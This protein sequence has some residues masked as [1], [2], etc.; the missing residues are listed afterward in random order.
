M[1]SNVVSQKNGIVKVTCNFQ[2]ITGHI[3]ADNCSTALIS[4]P[5]AKVTCIATN[6]DGLISGLYYLIQM[7]GSIFFSGITIG[8]CPSRTR[9]PKRFKALVTRFGYC[10]ARTFRQK[11]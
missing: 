8:I 3:H 10:D 11:N 9:K 4:Y 7:G 2:P 1:K 6:V 5:E